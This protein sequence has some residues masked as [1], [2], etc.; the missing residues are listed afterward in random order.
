MGGPHTVSSSLD[1]CQTLSG[2][3]TAIEKVDCRG[4]GHSVNEKSRD[5]LCKV[6]SQRAW[7]SFLLKF[8]MY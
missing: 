5:L 3:A 8:R 2:N 4:L 6:S 7:F 1:C